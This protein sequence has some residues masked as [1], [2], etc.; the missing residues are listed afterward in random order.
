MNNLIIYLFIKNEFLFQKRFIL[1]VSTFLCLKDSGSE[2]EREERIRGRERG[3]DSRSRSP[4]GPIMMEKMLIKPQSS[5]HVSLSPQ[6]PIEPPKTQ[7]EFD[8][9]KELE[10]QRRMLLQQ[11]AAHQHK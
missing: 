1:F 2:Y 7:E 9:L 3:P 5:G 8:D 10:K 11:L 4:E 6:L